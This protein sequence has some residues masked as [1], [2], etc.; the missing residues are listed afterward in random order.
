MEVFVTF[1]QELDSNERN[2]RTD[3]HFWD[4]DSTEVENKTIWTGYAGDTTL[5]ATS[6][7]DLNECLNTISKVYK[8]YH[9][10]LNADKTET[11]IFNCK[12]QANYHESIIEFEDKKIQNSKSFKFLGS[13]INFK[14]IGTGNVELNIRIQN[15][16][17]KCAEYNRLSTNQHIKHEWHTLIFL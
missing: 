1:D 15:A 17:L 16:K 4:L 8:D 2:V 13:T 11:M 6:K 14:E 7:A 5:Y 9:L 3:S 10:S 12:D